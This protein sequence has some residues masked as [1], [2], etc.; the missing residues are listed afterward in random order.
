MRALKG[1]RY[2]I[3]GVPGLVTV[4]GSRMYLPRCHRNIAS[5]YTW[6]KYEPETT[7]LIK[8]LLKPGDTFL[9]IGA[10]I[11]Y[12]SL[13]ASKLVGRT[14]RVLAFEPVMESAES[15][16]RSKFENRYYWLTVVELAISN[17]VG[18]GSIQIDGEGSRL[19]DQGG[20]GTGLCTVDKVLDF[21]FSLNKTVDVV[22][23][24][25]E[26]SEL[27]ILLGGERLFRDVKQLIIEVNAK[28]LYM[29]GSSVTEL[30][31]T[32]SRYGLNIEDR[33]YDKGD[34]YFNLHCWRV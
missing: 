11:G 19:V 6:D 23:I 1:L 26:G 21:S 14:G 4:Q 8:R 15:I 10:Y 32:L 30:Y 7:A 25:T 28:A 3:L 22:K 20:T 18:I 34:G 2:R 5:A 16:R 17:K 27:R 9:D 12:Y 29:Q 33:C 13:L 24:D 31:T